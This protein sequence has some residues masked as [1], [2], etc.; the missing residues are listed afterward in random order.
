MS[1]KDADDAGCCPLWAP[2]KKKHSFFDSAGR[3]S[4]SRQ[5]SPEQ[6]RKSFAPYKGGPSLAPRKSS[7]VGR[8]HGADGHIPEG[9]PCGPGLR[10]TGSRGLRWP[11]L[12]AAAQCCRPLHWGPAHFSLVLAAA[13]GWFRLACLF[14][15]LLVCAVHLRNEARVQ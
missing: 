9:R 12:R 1:A 11:D 3:C 15:C 6:I 7:A 2:P 10:T 5:K 13:F 4:K 14:A 8:R